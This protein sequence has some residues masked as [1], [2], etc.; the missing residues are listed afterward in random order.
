MTTQFNRTLLLI[1]ALVL[2]L[3]TVSG[4][5]YL[6][7]ITIFST[8]NA[9]N[10]VP[11]VIFETRF[12][13]NFDVW[14][15]SGAPGGPFLNGPTSATAQPN[16][17]LPT[18]VSTFT[19]LT[20]PGADSSLIGINLFFNGSAT[21]SISAY[22]PM[23]ALPGETHL[24][25]ADGAPQTAA[26][27]PTG[28]GQPFPGAGTLSAVFGNELVTLT[29]FYYA[30]PSVYNLD[31][32]GGYSTG[33]DTIKDYVGGITLSVTLVPEPQF[34]LWVFGLLTGMIA[35]QRRGRRSQKN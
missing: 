26:A 18:G 16:V 24:F 10:W 12:N 19:L 13:E 29:D 28:Y 14:I 9:G 21:P 5:T 33:P 7:D 22:G 17:S 20:D 4:Q 15:Q 35:L 27:V 32:V 11:P 34:S 3:G 31:L 23:L 30:T 25:L 2:P 6:T 1:T 8:D